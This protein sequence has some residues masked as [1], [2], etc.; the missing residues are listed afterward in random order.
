MLIYNVSYHPLIGI[1]VDTLFT[2]LQR[3]EQAP[4]FIRISQNSLNSHSYLMKSYFQKVQRIDDSG[5]LK[6]IL[7]YSN[8]AF[9]KL[10]LWLRGL[11][12]LWV[13]HSGSETWGLEHTIEEQSTS[14]SINLRLTLTHSPNKPST[15]TSGLDTIHH[16]RFHYR[17]GTISR[18]RTFV[19]ESSLLDCL[20][21]LKSSS[22]RYWKELIVKEKVHIR[23][24]NTGPKK[25]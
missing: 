24:Y 11:G 2:K 3:L 1:P 21:Y 8:L 17:Y 12:R 13:S 15:L 5:P 14:P 18:V 16:L 22:G 20:P 9:K 10:S 19:S 4:S 25:S 6:L 7:Y 23:I